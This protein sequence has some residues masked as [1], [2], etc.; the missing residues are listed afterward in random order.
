MLLFSSLLAAAFAILLLDR[1][2]FGFGDYL[3][4]PEETA[5]L[6]I[7]LWTA[8]PPILL[9]LAL[10]FIA[11]VLTACDAWRTLRAGSA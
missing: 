10:L 5:A 7:K 3:R 4:Y 2:S 11:S 8:F 6:H 1:M 9:S